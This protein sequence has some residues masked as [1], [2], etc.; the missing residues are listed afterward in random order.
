MIRIEQRADLYLLQEVITKT[1]FAQTFFVSR[2]FGSKK[3]NEMLFL[4]KSRFRSDFISF[5]LEIKYIVLFRPQ[6]PSRA[7]L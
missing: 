1:A 2:A 7:G 3:P 4:R 6:R 5:I